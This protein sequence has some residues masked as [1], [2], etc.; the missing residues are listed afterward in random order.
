MKEYKYII[1]GKEYTVSVG[2]R[3]DGISPVTVNGETY[4]VALVPEP[5]KERKVVVKAPASTPKTGEKDDLQD[6]LR[7]PLPGT[8]VDIPVNVGL[9]VK[10]GDTLIVLEAMKMDNNL[11]AERDGKIKAILVNEGD[12]V[13]ENTPL[14][15]FE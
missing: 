15:T 13:K 8:I 10:E 5:K 6:A 2:E 14:V 9:E 4:D 12:A 1:N 3:K 11:T 7:S